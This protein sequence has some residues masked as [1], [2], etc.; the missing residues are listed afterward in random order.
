MRGVYMLSA[1]GL[2]VCIGA[3][4][5]AIIAAA[6]VTAVI[7]ALV[8]VAGRKLRPVNPVPEPDTTSEAGAILNAMASGKRSVM[9]TMHETE[10]QR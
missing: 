1:A 9:P 3:N 6:A 2:C 5:V 4:E 7:V 10:V 8:W